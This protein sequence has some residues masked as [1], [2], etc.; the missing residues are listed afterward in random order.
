MRPK[1]GSGTARSR[2]HPMWRLPTRHTRRSRGWTASLLPKRG[3]GR[4]LFGGRPDAPAS[5]ILGRPD[6]LL[7]RASLLLST[8]AAAAPAAIPA[9]PVAAAIV[10]VA[11][12]IPESRNDD[13]ELGL[14]S[15]DSRGRDGDGCEE[16]R[17]QDCL[18]AE[19]PGELAPSH[20]I[21]SPCCGS[22]HLA[23]PA[24]D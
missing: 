16:T 9:L 21:L 17:K 1:P 12:M 13:L 14:G 20:A 8:P 3:G 18:Q 6:L 7:G 4:S 2:N 19:K 11:A 15:R 5:R 22:I 23:S 10:P 24:R